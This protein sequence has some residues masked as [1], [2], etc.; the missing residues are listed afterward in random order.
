ML[1][2]DLISDSALTN[3]PVSMPQKQHKT[4]LFDEEISILHCVESYKGILVVSLN[5]ESPDV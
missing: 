5:A 3:E 2:E 4:N 1:Q